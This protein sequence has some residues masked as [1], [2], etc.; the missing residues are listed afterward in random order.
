MLYLL[1]LILVVPPVIVGGLVHRHYHIFKRKDV[2]DV[3]YLL[4]KP[5][6]WAFLLTLYTFD[7]KPENR[8][9]VQYLPWEERAK[10]KDALKTK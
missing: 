10:I 4:M 7:K 6:E 9:A 8:I 2:S 3:T 5:F 1:L